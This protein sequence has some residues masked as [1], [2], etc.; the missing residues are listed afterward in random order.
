MGPGN[1][2][3]EVTTPT[4]LI[5]TQFVLFYKRIRRTQNNRK[6][7]CSLPPPSAIATKT[8][9]PT[10]IKS[11]EAGTGVRATSSKLTHEQRGINH[12]PKRQQRKKRQQR[13]QRQR[14]TQDEMSRS[15]PSSLDKFN[16]HTYK[17]VKKKKK[18]AS[19]DPSEIGF[20]N[21]AETPQSSAKKRTEK[22][23][24]FMFDSTQRSFVWH[25]NS[26]MGKTMCCS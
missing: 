2:Q 1:T 11:A 9:T 3:R 10:M 14:C 4:Y 15:A 26:N 23:S 24:V 7:C 25:F 17:C 8:K 19:G 12:Q 13:Q 5:K 20:S 6:I 18:K 16:L 22:T 21:A